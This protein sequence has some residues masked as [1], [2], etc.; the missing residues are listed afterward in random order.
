MVLKELKMAPSLDFSWRL[1]L[2]ESV[3]GEVVEP[4]VFRVPNAVFAAC[5]APIAY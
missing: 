5:P 2:V 3:Q 4:G 1:D